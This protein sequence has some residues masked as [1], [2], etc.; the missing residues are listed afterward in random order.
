MNGWS[1]LVATHA[2]AAGLGLLLGAYQLL[3][4]VKGDRRHRVAGW[5][6]VLAM[7]YVA[8]SSFGIRE[9]A[10]GRFSLLHALSVV[11]LV[12]LVLGILAARRGDVR[13]HRGR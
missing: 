7:T 3:R 6:W 5:V 4:R 12:S 13:R 2:T 11:T 9:L 10:G 8:T 1:V